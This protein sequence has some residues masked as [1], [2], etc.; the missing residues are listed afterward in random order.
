MKV[1]AYVRV[2]GKGQIKGTG[3]DRQLETI[4]GFCSRE[5]HEIDKVFQ[6]QVSGT[7]DETDRIEFKAMVSEIMKDGVDTIVVESLNR[8]AR[9]YRITEP[10]MAICSRGTLSGGF[11]TGRKGWL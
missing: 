6:E 4:Q 8:L 1:Y 5:G 7:T 3:Y 2:S 10:T 11:C 9:E